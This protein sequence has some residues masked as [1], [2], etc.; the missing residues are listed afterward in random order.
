MKSDNEILTGLLTVAALICMLAAEGGGDVFRVSSGNLT[1]IWRSHA[2]DA[3][4]LGQEKEAA[5]AAARRSLAD[6]L[7]VP[8]DVKWSTVEKAGFQKNTSGN[9]LA[10]QIEIESENG[11]KVL[12]HWLVQLEPGTN[13]ILGEVCQ[14]TTPSLGAAAQR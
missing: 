11:E 1:Q 13:R 5:Y 14:A 10:L 7:T 9:F 6:T 4:I 3:S 8:G 12:K 2:E